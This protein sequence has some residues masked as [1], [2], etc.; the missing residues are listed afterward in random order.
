MITPIQPVDP[1]R[2]NV[3]QPASDRISPL[4][5]RT[6]SEHYNALRFIGTTLLPF[7]LIPADEKD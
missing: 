1:V 4:A 7:H 6:L 2:W 3:F 5:I